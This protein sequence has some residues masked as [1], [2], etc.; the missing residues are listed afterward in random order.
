MVCH[1]FWGRKTPKSLVMRSM[2][3][4]VFQSNGVI[5]PTPDGSH[6]QLLDLFDFFLVL[7]VGAL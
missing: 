7:G 1:F 6:G 2:Q 5:P 4:A 3:A